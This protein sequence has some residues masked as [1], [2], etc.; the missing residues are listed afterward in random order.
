MSEI[1]PHLLFLISS[2]AFSFTIGLGILLHFT[3]LDDD[4][5]SILNSEYLGL[6]LHKLGLVLGWGVCVSI[7]SKSLG[8]H[9]ARDL[10]FVKVI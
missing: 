5:T 10:Y 6:S 9:S 2:F 3:S 8:M 4:S 7:C 1:N